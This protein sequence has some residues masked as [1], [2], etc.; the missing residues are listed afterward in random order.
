MFT[1]PSVTPAHH[2]YFLEKGFAL[3][4]Q[5][6][7]SRRVVTEL[8]HE[9]EFVFSPKSFFEQVPGDV[10]IQLC[11]DSELFSIS[12]TAFEQ[13]ARKFQ[14]ANFL[15]CDIAA[16]YYTKSQGRMVDINTLDTWQRY[17]KLMSSHPG[18][19]LFVS[20][21]MIASYLSITPQSLSRLKSQN[22]RKE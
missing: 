22:Y 10:I 16:D 2:A 15:A 18:I 3:A 4:F 12:R 1:T 6:A 9:G 13:L 14:V 20:Q 5:Y 19:E 11:T 7:S 21:E 17:L 8:W